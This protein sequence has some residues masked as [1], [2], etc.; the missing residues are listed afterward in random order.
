MMK[1]VV[2]FADGGEKAG[3]ILFFNQQKT[4]FHLQSDTGEGQTEAQMVRL[5]DVKKILFPKK[6]VPSTSDVHYETIKQS[7]FAGTFAYK[8]VVEFHDGELLTGSTIKYNPEDKGFFLIPL[9]PADPNERIYVNSQHIKK[10]DI[11][12]LFGK[13]LADHQM[14]NENQL[15]EAILVQTEKRK[16]KIGSIMVEE[17]MI[18]QVQ[19]DESLRRQRERNIKLGELLVESG[20]ITLEQLNK[21]LRI[22]KE[23][24]RKRLGQIMVELKFLTP[25]DICLALA[26]QLHYPWVDLSTIN[27]SDEII[28]LLPA[29]VIKKY[30][31]VPIEKKDVDT[32][33]VASAQP[34]DPEMQK[35]LNSLTDLKL[36]F[37]VA[38]DGYIADFI[39]RQFFS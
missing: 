15:K 14:I 18:S 24:R 35:T 5:D 32:L 11:N 12:K 7:T 26:S 31:V 8:L 9:N 13:Y 27:I 4:F 23:Y 2:N 39:N 22:Q 33:V 17:T 3:S 36:N 16:K 34:Q 20:Y 1:V 10:V 6:K 25:N 19:L 38:Y 21:A 30:E 37:V 29:E 28:N